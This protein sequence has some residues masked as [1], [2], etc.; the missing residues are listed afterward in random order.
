[1]EHFTIK[2]VAELFGISAHTLRYYD[3]EG[4]FPDM[5]RDER[6][7]RAFTPEQLDWLKMVI[8]L[9]E[10]GMS[11]SE[12]KHYIALAQRGDSTLK[13]RYEIIMEQRERALEA[14]EDAHRKLELLDRKAAYYRDLLGNQ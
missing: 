6:G 14:L 1:M 5:E 10:T 3:N 11:V 8:C 13:E 12:I 9:R 7:A 2:Q 4:L